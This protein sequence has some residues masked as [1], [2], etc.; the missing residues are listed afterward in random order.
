MSYTRHFRWAKLTGWASKNEQKSK[1]LEHTEE[2]NLKIKIILMRHMGVRGKENTCV[3]L[4]SDCL[5]AEQGRTKVE[6]GRASTLKKLNPTRPYFHHVSVTAVP[7][8]YGS[9]ARQTIS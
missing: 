1:T 9:S 4:L 2:K 5:Q 8:Q 7:H 3:V 6:R